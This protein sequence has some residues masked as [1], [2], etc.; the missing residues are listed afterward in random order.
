MN[1]I[2]LEQIVKH[3]YANLLI[4]PSDH[5]DADNSKSLMSDPYKLDDTLK[6]NLGS[7][8]RK[9]YVKYNP[10]WGCEI[11]T[12]D[13]EL[14]ILLGDCSDDQHID[15]CLLVHLKNSPA[16]GIYFVHDENIDCEAMIACTLNN[17]DWLTCNTYLQATFLAAMEQ[18]KELGLNWRKCTSYEEELKMMKSFINYHNDCFTQQ[19]D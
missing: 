6:F 13:Q 17:Q 12:G 9:S 10:I 15:Y 19:E 18:C 5:V 3:I 2:L 16:Y 14:K 4:I 11:S 8:E 7:V 1:K